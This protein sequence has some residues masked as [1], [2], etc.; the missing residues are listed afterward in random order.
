MIEVLEELLPKSYEAELVEDLVSLMAS[1]SA[2]I[3]GRRSAENRR[4]KANLSLTHKRNCRIDN[5]LHTSS[6]RIVDWC[7]R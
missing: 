1:M 7:N 2:K 6:R 3:Y 4:K 5:Y